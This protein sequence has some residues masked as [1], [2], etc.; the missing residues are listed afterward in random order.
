[1]DGI[2]PKKI[3]EVT[4]IFEVDL[5]DRRHYLE[6]S[7]VE[8]L[9]KDIFRIRKLIC[10]NRPFPECR[11]DQNYLQ[12]KTKKD[13]IDYIE[14]REVLVARWKLTTKFD[15]DRDRLEN[16]NK[17]NNYRQRQLESLSTDECTFGYAMPVSLRRLLWRGDTIL[18][19]S[20]TKRTEVKSERRGGVKKFRSGPTFIILLDDDDEDGPNKENIAN[21]RQHS[22]SAPKQEQVYTYGDTCEFST[23]VPLLNIA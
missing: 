17:P 1:M 13:T 22:D 16:P 9:R 10:T 4:F 8:V 20:G 2:V 14:N 3:N 11:F 23:I 18:G 7:V 15:N 12:G 19:G 6:Q 5:N 21:I